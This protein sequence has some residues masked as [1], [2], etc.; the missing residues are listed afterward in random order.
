MHSEVCALHCLPRAQC[1]LCIRRYTWNPQHL[2]QFPLCTA[3]SARSAHCAPHIAHC[4]ICSP[5]NSGHCGSLHTAPC[6]HCTLHIRYSA[7]YTPHTA[8]WAHCMCTFCTLHTMHCPCTPC[9]VL[10]KH[11]LCTLHAVHTVHNLRTAHSAHCTF[12]IL[13]MVYFAHCASCILRMHTTQ[14]AVC[15]AHVGYHT[16]C[17]LCAN[18]HS[19]HCV[20]NAPCQLPTAV[21]CIH[22]TLQTM[23]RLFALYTLYFVTLHTAQCVPCNVYP[24]P[25]APFVKMMQNVL[26]QK[27]KSKGLKDFYST[28]TDDIPTA[29][30]LGKNSMSAWLS[31]RGKSEPYSKFSVKKNSCV[32][33]RRARC[34]WNPSHSIVQYSKMEP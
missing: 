32:G 23:P 34:S 33:R 4:T 17:T 6:A 2:G 13:H 25:S 15:S 31:M 27:H 8:Q 29:T 20:C 22:C 14:C 10:A 12:C 16:L 18:A 24:A 28:H 3:H 26:S 30:P 5:L 9:T 21:H 11:C 1:A 7:R 19:A